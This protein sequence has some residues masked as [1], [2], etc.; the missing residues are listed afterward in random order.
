MR[1]KYTDLKEIARPT[2]RLNR[3][4][5]EELKQVLKDKGT[6]LQEVCENFL[7]QWLEENKEVVK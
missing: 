7:H 1:K 3:T 4:F 6:S 2:I 5:N